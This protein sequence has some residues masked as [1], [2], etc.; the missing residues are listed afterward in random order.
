[1][2][3]S[4][5][6]VADRYM[7][8]AGLSKTAGEVRF[9]KDR[10][11]DKN[12][13]GWGSPGPTEREIQEDFEYNPK[14]MKPLAETLRAALLA[15]GHALSAHATFNRIKSAQVSP[16]GALG[17][18]GYI[19]KI[20]DMRRQLMNVCE[21]LSSLTDTLYD[22]IKAPHW[23]P[24]VE[25]QGK[26]ERDEVKNIMDDVDEIRSDP[27]GFAEEEEAKMDGDED[28]VSEDSGGA[29]SEGGDGPSGKYARKKLASLD[30]MPIRVAA[31]YLD[32]T[33]SA[34]T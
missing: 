34:R 22:E 20:P 23:N 6:E 29:V 10:G 14:N 32:Q 7:K 2:I 16:D 12:E 25:S 18:K 8:K 15:M 27:E 13:W 9:I 33:Q 30:P 24:A 31:Q 26:R 28:S 11:G 17:G 3:T 1:M 19:Q 4:P 21:A 5:Q